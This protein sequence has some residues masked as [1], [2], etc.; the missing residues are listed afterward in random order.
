[1]SVQS[2]PRCTTLNMYAG[3]GQ[4]PVRGPWLGSCTEPPPPNVGR[5]TDMTENITIPQLHCW[6]VNMTGWAIANIN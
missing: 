6:A 4:G 5:Q 3:W 2:D 1:M